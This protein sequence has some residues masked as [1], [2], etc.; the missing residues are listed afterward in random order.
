VEIMRRA[1]QPFPMR[2]GRAVLDVSR[3]QAPKKLDTLPGR[4]D[5]PRQRSEQEVVAPIVLRLVRG[6]GCQGLQQVVDAG[7]SP[8]GEIVKRKKQLIPQIHAH[9]PRRPG[10][11]QP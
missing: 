1:L 3:H 10:R 11:L 9:A 8:T 2:I 4:I 6:P 7:S 5:E